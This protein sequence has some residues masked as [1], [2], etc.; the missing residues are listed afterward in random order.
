[1]TKWIYW[2]RNETHEMEIFLPCSNS[3]CSSKKKPFPSSV[4][5]SQLRYRVK[6]GGENELDYKDMV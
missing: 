4:K 3:Y 5:G 6:C 1:M 2:F